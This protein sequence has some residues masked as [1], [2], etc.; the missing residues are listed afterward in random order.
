MVAP[1]LPSRRSDVIAILAIFALAV[2]ARLAVQLLLGFYASPESFEEGLIARDV[3]AGRGYGFEMFGTWQQAFRAPLYPLLLGALY[4]L[5]GASSVVAGIFQLILGGATAAVA[6]AVGWR[7]G[8]RDP[9]MLAGALVATHPGLLVYAAKIHQ[10]SLDALLLTASTLVLLLSLASPA[11]KLGATYGVIGGLLALTRP[12]ALPF[13]PI[14]AGLVALREL[15][16]GG[17]RWAFIAVA[18]TAGLSAVWVVRNA[19]T[20]GEPTLSTSTGLFIWTGNNRFATGT[21]LT[22][23]GHPMYL[24][25]IDLVTKVQGRDEV[26]Q[27]RIFRDAALSYM[28]EDPLRTTRHLVERAVAF[29]WFTP[30][31]GSGYP[32]AWLPLY[33]AY[34]IVALSGAIVGAATL[35][36]AGRRA[37]MATLAGLP[38]VVGLTQ[39]LFYVE[40]RH[41]WG[42]EPIVL[43]LSAFG[44]VWAVRRL[45]GAPA[46]GAAETS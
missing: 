6:A 10:L 41:R 4:T 8:G 15:T 25:D 30:T 34:W 11:A 9:G 7:L 21:A 1:V 3:A 16:R 42:I 26:E 12:T 27:D 2:A 44:A 45:R 23:D 40:G 36:R 28:I 5:F 29:W 19:V 32:P 24:A 14:A 22:S 37:E 46:P 18:L 39:A 43:V 13:V 38:V 31:S 35:W 20:V 17:M 33:A